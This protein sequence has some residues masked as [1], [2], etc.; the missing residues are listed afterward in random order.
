MS[1]SFAA[2]G[3]FH[4][5]LTNALAQ[6]RADAAVSQGTLAAEL[7]ID[8]AAVSRVEANQRRL[9]AGETF[10]WLEALGLTAEESAALLQHLWEQHGSR[11][12]GFWDE[13]DA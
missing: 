9:T 12:A 4:R 2:E 13:S 1:P 7:G 11:P 3:D 6:K 10:A 5:A 8:Q